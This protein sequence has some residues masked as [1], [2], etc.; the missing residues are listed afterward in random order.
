MR[1]LMIDG[2]LASSSGSGFGGMHSHPGHGSRHSLGSAMF[3][4]GRAWLP[5]VNLYEMPDKFLVC[6]DLAGVK[7]D[8]IDV[9]INDRILRVEGKRHD[10]MPEKKRVHLLEIDEGLFCREVEIPA[11]VD[12]E[13][14][15]AEYE[16]GF[17]WVHLPKT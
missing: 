14:I 7:R 1:E 17:L 10:P 11:T 2:Q 12:V 15:E 6:V 4:P 8:E 3:R 9:K 16:D 5:P 13:K